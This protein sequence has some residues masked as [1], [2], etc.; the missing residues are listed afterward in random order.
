VD[1][2]YLSRLSADA[3]TALVELPAE[4]GVLADIEAA[5]ADE[6]PWSSFNVSRR[7]ARNLLAFN[8]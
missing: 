6:E 7:R 8:S 1:G 3:A 4:L 5:L 2:S